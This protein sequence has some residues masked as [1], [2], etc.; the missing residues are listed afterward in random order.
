[1]KFDVHSCLSNGNSILFSNL[2]SKK[3]LK[4]ETPSY[5]FDRVGIKGVKTNPNIVKVSVQ[6]CYPMR[7]QIYDQILIKGNWSKEKLRR[8]VQLRFG[9]NGVKIAQDIAK[10]NVHAS[11]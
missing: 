8:V 4:I 6:D 1:M 11:L 2:N 9:L 10:V 5:G 3:S 7:I